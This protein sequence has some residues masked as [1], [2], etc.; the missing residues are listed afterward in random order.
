HR[1]SHLSPRNI[2]YES[3]LPCIT[4][5]SMY[6]PRRFG[7]PWMINWICIILGVTLMILAQIGGLRKLIIQAKTYQFYS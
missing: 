7:M 2:C 1:H 4:W 3:P 6:N 5:L